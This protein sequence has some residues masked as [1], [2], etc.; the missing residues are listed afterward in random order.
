MNTLGIYY[1]SDTYLVSLDVQKGTS[2][3]TIVVA[4]EKVQSNLNFTLQ[5]FSKVPIEFKPVEGGN[6]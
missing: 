2:V 4:H 1:Y 6:F 5:I 3:F